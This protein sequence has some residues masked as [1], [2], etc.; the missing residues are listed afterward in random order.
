MSYVEGNHPAIIEPSIFNRVQEELARRSGKRKVKQVGTKT[1][2]GKYSSKY[3]LTELLVCGD[4]G[5]PYRRCTWTIG[6]KK[7]IVWRCINRLD[8]GKKYCKESATIEESLIQESIMTAVKETAMKNADILK[9]LKIHIGM[10]LQSEVAEDKSLDIQIKIAEADAKFRTLLEATNDENKDDSLIESKLEEIL[11]EKKLLSQQLE[12]YEKAKQHRENTQS[13][14]DEIFT[15]L[16]GLKNHPIAYDDQIVRQILSCVVVESKEK[17]KIV[18]AG[19][20]E[21]EQ[22]I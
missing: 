10:G 1:E 9:M 7:K 2:Q 21:V 14:L 17:I 3:A 8:Y 4:C 13:R 20:F 16:D 12:Q 15:V 22:A 6:G 18:F 11:H 5:T 19:G